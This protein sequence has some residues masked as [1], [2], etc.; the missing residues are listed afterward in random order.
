MKKILITGANSYVGTNVEKWLM[1]EPDKYYVETLDMKDP[2]WKE[3]DFSKF[4]VVFH[5][6]AIVHIK[7]K[8]ENKELYYLI[9][10]DM[11]IETAKKAKTSGVSQ[12]ILMS[13]MNVYGLKKG[14]ISAKT[15]LNPITE[16]GKSKRNAE[17]AI[18]SLDS[19]A[20]KVVIVRP[21][22]IYGPEAVGN[23]LQLS[24]FVKKFRIFPKI[25]NK[26][27]FIFIDHFSEF[28]RI[29]VFTS[30]RGIFH[31]QNSFLVS[32]TSIVEEIDKLYSK[33]ILIS[34]VFN[35][36]IL[37]SFINKVS[38]IFSSLYYDKS[39]YT[40]QELQIIKDSSLYDFNKTIKLTE[41]NL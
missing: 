23:Y 21:P 41:E 2:N 35:F 9:N 15:R 30:A 24:K 5:V 7:E 19:S 8:K 20:F 37:F 26:K 16:Y 40:E 22:M 11:A 36:I 12:F 18:Q 38:K 1:K 31:P 17:V 3:F 33:K 27:S 13:T 32:A 34:K 28:I 10:Q 25:N 14:A 29:I 4:D 6:A 39:L